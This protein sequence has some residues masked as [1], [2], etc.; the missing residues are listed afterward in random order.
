M[1]GNK[2]Q[3]EIRDNRFRI[4][5]KFQKKKT[6]KILLIKQSRYVKKKH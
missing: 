6:R 3:N 1:R 4:E 2:H 5:L